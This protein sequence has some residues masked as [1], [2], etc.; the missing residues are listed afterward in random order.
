V[1]CDFDYS[2]EW[3]T[4]YDSRPESVGDGK[5]IILR[6]GFMSRGRRT[7]FSF[8]RQ[9]SVNSDKDLAGILGDVIMRELLQ[10]QKLK[11][12]KYATR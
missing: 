1:T 5:D 4:Y 12:F 9:I 3:R 8:E 10:H 2:S 7:S 11:T 6:R